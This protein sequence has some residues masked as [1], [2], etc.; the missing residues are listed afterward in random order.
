M[1]SVNISRRGFFGH[2]AGAY[3]A[4]AMTGGSIALADPVITFLREWDVAVEGLDTVPAGGSDD[5][6]HRVVEPYESRACEGN[7]PDATTAEG[8]IAAIRKALAFN[9]MENQDA[10]LVRSALAYLEAQTA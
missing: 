10:S 8:A 2:A 3:S 1:A 7:I 9:D 6:W 5:Y 4:I